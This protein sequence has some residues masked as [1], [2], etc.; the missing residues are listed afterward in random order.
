MNKV[1]I[2]REKTNLGYPE[3]ASLIKKAIN[4]ALEAENISQACEVSVLLTDDAGIREMNRTYRGVD[5]V[6]DVLSFPMNELT[7]GAFSPAACEVDPENGCIVLGDMMIDLARCAEQGAEFG[8]GFQREV[9]YLTVHSIL[10]LLGYDHVDEGAMKRQMRMR[11]KMIMGDK[12][13]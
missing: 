13:D 6:T 11:E 9:M 2:T 8:H 12:D 5:A 10:H 3:A 7:P 1:Y 4:M